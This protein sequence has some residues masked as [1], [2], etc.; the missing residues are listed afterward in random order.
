[1][2]ASKATTRRFYL[3]FYDWTWWVWLVTAVLLVL[4][5]FGRPMAFIAAMVVTLVQCIVML[6]REGSFLAFPVQIRF[7]YFLVLFVCS[8]PHL[9]LL[10]WIPT[11][12]TFALV[13]FGYCI[14]ARVVSLLPWNRRGPLTDDLLHRTFRS[15]PDLSRV[16][17]TDGPNGCAGNLCSIEAQVAPAD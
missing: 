6:L 8:L 3:L 4:G 1:M 17:P 7:A 10:Y 12:S 9:R 2:Q 5:L 15:R 13:L 14:L 11:I 16:K